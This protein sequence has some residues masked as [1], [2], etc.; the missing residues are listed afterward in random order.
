[1]SFDFLFGNSVIRKVERKRKLE[2][3]IEVLK[4]QQKVEIEKI[5]K[6]T[7]EKKANLADSIDAQVAALNAQINNLKKQ[8]V[9]QQDLLDEQRK[10][11]I[12]K[13]VNDFNQKITAKQN[14]V[15]R[16]GHFIDA[17]RKNQEDALNPE[18]PN[19]PKQVL[20]ETK[21]K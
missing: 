12:D 7:D 8:K 6:L 14:K 3:E 11:E 18:Q 17:E 20:L 19:A 21:K 1:M 10:V 5:S 9:T 16:L 2:G 13:K 4:K 15:K